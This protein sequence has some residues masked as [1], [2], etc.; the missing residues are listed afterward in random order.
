MKEKKPTMLTYIGEEQKYLEEMLGRYPKGIPEINGREWLVLATGSSINAAYS[1]KYYIEKMTDI[2]IEIEEPFKFQYYE[3]LRPEIETVI[4]ISQSGEST[5]TINALAEI[6][7]GNPSIDT[8]GMTSN[9]ESEITKVV[10]EN[11]DIEMGEEKV[12]YVTKGFSVTVFKL[13]LIGLKESRRR[14]LISE[15]QETAEL[16]NFKKAFKEIPSII[17]KTNIFFQRWREELCKA[18]RFTALTCGSTIGTAYEMQTK[19]CETVRIPSQGMDIEVFMHG[20]YLEVNPSHQLFF[21][22]S[23]S[24]LKERLDRLRKYE[25]QYVNNVY[26]ISLG[27]SSSKKD[28][29]TIYLNLNE[30]DEYKASLFLIIPFQ[31]LAYHISE[32]LGRHLEHRIYTDFGVAMQSKTKPGDYV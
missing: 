23:N 28:D 27:E 16:E 5:S 13:M 30:I 32:A 7:A 3:K 25:K 8:Y 19:F 20:P 26:S 12:G 18:S 9:L 4:G 21:I 24:P 22:E 1:A 6:S 2:I 10:K 14:G 31:I 17:K 29:K 15:A 11:I